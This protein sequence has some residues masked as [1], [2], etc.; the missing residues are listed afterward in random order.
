MS[1]ANLDTLYYIIILMLFTLVFIVAGCQSPSRHRI[2][3]DKVAIDIIKEKQSQILGNAQEFTIERPSDIL[4]SR[5]LTEQHLQYSCEASLGSDRL[6]APENWPEKEYPKENVLSETL[7]LL[8]GN[9]PLK[10]SLI[11]ALQIGAR[12]SFEYQS[13]KEEIFRYALNLDLYR[14]GFR[15]SYEGQVES[16]MSSD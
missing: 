14:D 10:I 11:Q 5:L 9:R 3:A 6:K 1:Y 2:K 16:L 15:G 4:R 7:M 13:N 8:D 12:N